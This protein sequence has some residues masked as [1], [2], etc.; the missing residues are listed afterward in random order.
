MTYIY[1][2]NEY[3]EA[4][5]IL[6]RRLQSAFKKSWMKRCKTS[7]ELS[8]K[9][10]EPLYDVCAAVL[11]INDRKELAE[12]LT[13]RD[14]LWD[15][16]V[17]VILTNHVDISQTEVLTLRPRFLAWTDADLSHVVDILGNMMKH[18][19]NRKVAA[20]TSRES[21]AL[22]IEEKGDGIDGTDIDGSRRRC[23]RASGKTRGQVPHI[24]HGR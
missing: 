24:L 1:Y 20:V 2:A 15:I 14:M 21:S 13:L 4:G 19:P 16:K 3:T 23:R 22:I 11:L 9:L 7:I 6:Y 8:R 17:I 18:K 5:K 10:H 12:I